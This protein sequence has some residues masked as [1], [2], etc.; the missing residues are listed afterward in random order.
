MIVPQ[1]EKGDMDMVSAP[2]RGRSEIYEPELI[3]EDFRQKLVAS[4]QKEKDRLREMA[5]KE[6]KL[7]L[8]KAY[9][10]SA[11]LTSKAQ[12]ESVQIISQAKEKARQDSEQLIS[13]AQ[14]KVEQI[15]KNADEIT[16]REAKE[17]TR[18]E[19]ETI[20]RNAKEEAA[21][22]TSKT[23]QAAKDE[24]NDL[25]D[26]AKREAGMTSRQLIDDAQ[27]EAA[28]ITR[29]ANELKQKAASELATVHEKT[30]EAVERAM[31][32]IRKTATD[33][34]EKE[35]ADIIAQAKTRALK[36]KELLLANAMVEARKNA[37]SENAL[38]LQKAHQQAEE[39]VNSAKNKMRIQIEESSRLMLEIQQK[40]QQVIGNAGSETKNAVKRPFEAE[41]PEPLSSPVPAK[42][43]EKIEPE[44][45]VRP[46]T[47]KESP[48]ISETP[49]KVNSLVFDE[50]TG[51]Y[52]GK[53]KI[54]IA[55]PVDNEQIAI[56]EKSLVKTGEIR[57]IVKGGA[58]DGSAWIEIDIAKPIALL[59][60][61][62]NTPSVKD[63]VGA[64]SY[65]IVALKSK[66][67]V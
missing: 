47:Q 11:G 50:Q 66:Q 2:E 23:L 5:D 56:L 32:S 40:M 45:T 10:E 42:H 39:I 36:E 16:R 61:L 28:E 44:V 53:L 7:I 6:A 59:D 58:E 48:A 22:I 35:A 41:E 57:V 37:D 14:Q 38:I 17:K 52:K 55:P 1:P 26:A 9:Q 20:I 24:A 62:R 67:L 30:S 4:L 33:A 27:K 51:T 8:T 54:D 15:V 46:G 12:E 3:I 60:I 13:Q 31:A 65:I 64:K 25:I 49:T 18:K 63:D 21:K 34:A 29:S 43:D 19:M